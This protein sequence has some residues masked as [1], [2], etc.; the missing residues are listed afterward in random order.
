MGMLFRDLVADMRQR[1]AKIEGLKAELEKERQSA[2]NHADSASAIVA[3]ADAAANLLPH[4]VD[5]IAGQAS[6]QTAVIEDAIKSVLEIASPIKV[7][8]RAERS[9]RSYESAVTHLEDRYSELLIEHKVAWKRARIDLQ[10]AYALC[11]MAARR[12][13]APFLAGKDIYLSAT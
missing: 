12:R 9:L 1:E 3:A 8:E 13:S 10:T 4:V 6:D 7:R 2:L 5:T 11:R